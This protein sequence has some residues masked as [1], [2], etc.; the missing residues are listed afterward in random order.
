M[1]KGMKI[2]VED[3][4]LFLVN[5]AGDKV[6]IPKD[7]AAWV[8]EKLKEGCHGCID[9]LVETLPV[10]EDY[11]D[12]GSLYSEYLTNDPS[13][14]KTTQHPLDPNQDGSLPSYFKGSEANPIQLDEVI[15][16][17]KA[18]EW[19]KYYRE[20]IKNNPFNIDEY[21]ESRYNNPVGR[22]VIEKIDGDSW[23]KKL[24]QEGLE[25]RYNSA[26]D[27]VGEQ[28]VKNKP[29]GKLTRAEWLN[30]M[31]DKE[32]EIIKRNPK[33]QPSLWTDTKRGLISLVEQNPLQTFYH[34][35]N[36][37]DYSNREKEKC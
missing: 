4:E 1:D 29:Q 16:T 28:L 7:K 18:P 33:Y 22:E 17:A 8:K 31:S 12:D 14:K 5:E 19:L 21:V 37:S 13:T 15:V 32:E 23:R 24:K 34:I 10:M 3:R 36:S 35:L 9:K 27:Y 20:Y 2:E 26:M 25:K 11:A 30:S 6:I